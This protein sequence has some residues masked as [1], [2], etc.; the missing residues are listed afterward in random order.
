[1]PLIR[2]VGPVDRVQ[3]PRWQIGGLGPDGEPGWPRLVPVDVSEE[4]RD[5][6]VG[7][8]HPEWE[9]ADGAPTETLEG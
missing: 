3:V 1:M 8:G 7:D 5:D 9:D 6:L 4:A 2:Y